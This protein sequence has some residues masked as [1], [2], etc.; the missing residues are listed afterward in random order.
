MMRVGVHLPNDGVMEERRWGQLGGMGL[1]KGLVRLDGPS[2]SS[3]WRADEVDWGRLRAATGEGCQ[4]VLRW[5]WRGRMVAGKVIRM[6]DERLPGILEVLGAGNCLIEIGNEP[7]HATGMEGFGRLPKHAREFGL[8]YEAVLDGLRARGYDNL[9]F[10]GLAV[11]EFAHGERTWGRMC[12]DLMEAS[13]WVGVHCY[14]QLPEQVGDRTFGEN[15][16]WYVRS[17]EKPV[18]VTEAGNSSCHTPS[19][20]QVGPERQAAEY[21]RWCEG[22]RDW[23]RGVA[24]F[25]LDGSEEWRGFR[26]Y[27]ETLGALARLN[28]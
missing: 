17:V 11:A 24:F 4:Y 23:V 18:Y 5:Y 3:G 22:A 15:W 7:N 10:P 20:P 28:V 9:G 19:L 13:D 27:D 26:L 2:T 8:W 6:V 21:G 16:W 14:W 1:V 12:R 25:M